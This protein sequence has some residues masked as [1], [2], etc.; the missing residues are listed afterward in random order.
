MEYTYEKS[1]YYAIISK[2]IAIEETTAS[3]LGHVK[4][5]A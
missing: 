4:V 1:K 2:A 5:S 3:E